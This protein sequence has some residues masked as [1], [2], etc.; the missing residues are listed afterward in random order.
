MDDKPDLTWGTVDVQNLQA[1]AK[2]DQKEDEKAARRVR[3]AVR[4]LQR[5]G[6]LDENGRRIRQSIPPDMRDGAKTDFGC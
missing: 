3:D 2:L 1:M 4:R 5:Q 6:V